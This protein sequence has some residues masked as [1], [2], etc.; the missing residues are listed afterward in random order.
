MIP[1]VYPQ[2][3]LLPRM[4]VYVL[5]MHLLTYISLSHFL[6]FSPFLSLSLSGIN[7]LIHTQISIDAL[8]R[9]LVDVQLDSSKILDDL[10]TGDHPSLLYLSA[11]LCAFV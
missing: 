7:P 11:P 5:C 2:D 1:Y 4:V 9:V 3:R 6:P 8:S 10:L